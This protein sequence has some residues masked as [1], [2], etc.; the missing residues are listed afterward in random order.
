MAGVA[1]GEGDVG[2][3]GVRRG[4]ERAEENDEVQ[5]AGEAHD[6]AA[7]QR[8]QQMSGGVIGGNDGGD[9][10]ALA[11][12]NHAAVKKR[13]DFGECHAGGRAAGACHDWIECQPRWRDGR[14]SLGRGSLVP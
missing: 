13:A 9:F 2:E 4:G 1:E 7:D 6:A 12:R 11:G 10:A 3:R 14:G 5:D 8:G